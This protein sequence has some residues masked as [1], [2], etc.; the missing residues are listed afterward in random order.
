M[1]RM[2]SGDEDMVVVELR[3][4][5]TRLYG[6]FIEA[7]LMFMLKTYRHHSTEALLRTTKAT[8]A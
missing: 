7:V 3:R 2:G 8:A 6:E 4:E 1:V 5:L